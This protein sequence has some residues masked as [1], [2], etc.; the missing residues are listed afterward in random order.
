MELFPVFAVFAHSAI[1]IIAS[2][3]LWGELMRKQ[4]ASSIFF[5]FVLAV[6]AGSTNS[7]QAEPLIPGTG[8]KVKEASDDFEDTH[9][10]FTHNFP[11]SSRNLDGR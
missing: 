5:C 11:K 6:A 7:V 9:W 1:G 8:E 4:L 3:D 2:D 10:T